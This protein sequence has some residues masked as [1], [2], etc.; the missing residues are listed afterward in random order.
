MEGQAKAAEA[1]AVHAVH[2]VQR[3]LRVRI[4]PAEGYAVGHAELAGKRNEVTAAAMAKYEAWLG[5]NVQRNLEVVD[6]VVD[7]STSNAP[8]VNGWTPLQLCVI[9]VKYYG[10][11]VP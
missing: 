11:D 9:N 8:S 6:I 7:N 5:R 10:D 1:Q 4:F 3:M 2:A